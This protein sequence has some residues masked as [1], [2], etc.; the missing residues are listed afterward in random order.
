MLD[1]PRSLDALDRIGEGIFALDAGGGSRTPTGRRSSCFPGLI[2]A[3]GDLVGTV[4]W[5]ASPSF[6]ETPT[7]VALRR[8]VEE[9]VPS[10]TASAIPAPVA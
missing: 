3:G 7:G 10:S 1:S 6:A 4:V 9:G 5:D 8:A 2:G